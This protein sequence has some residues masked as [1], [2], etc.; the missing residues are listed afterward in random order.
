MAP[1]TVD[2]RWGYQYDT[3]KVFATDFD[4]LGFNCL[5]RENDAFLI[6]PENGYVVQD[7]Y[8]PDNT[9]TIVKEGKTYFRITG[10]GHV[11]FGPLQSIKSPLHIYFEFQTLEGGIADDSM[12][13]PIQDWSIQVFFD[14]KP[15]SITVGR[16]IAESDNALLVEYTTGAKGVRYTGSLDGFN[17]VE[18]VYNGETDG[19]GDYAL[20]IRMSPTEYNIHFHPVTNTD[21]AVSEKLVVTWTVYD[22]SDVSYPEGFT[23]AVGANGHV[24]VRT[25]DGQKPLG[26]MHGDEY[27]VNGVVL[28]LFDNAYILHINALAQPEGDVVD[29]DSNRVSVLVTTDTVASGSANMAAGL[30][31]DEQLTFSFDGLMVHYDPD[32]TLTFFSSAG[33]STGTLVMFSGGWILEL[34]IIASPEVML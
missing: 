4:D 32:G 20:T 17:A 30:L 25:S 28:S 26:F 34:S 7:G 6:S 33:V 16:T 3:V 23:T 14:S 27:S 13:V 19:N 10:E 9:E 29:V 18:G 5:V 31:G 12:L 2:G 24:M 15:Y 22:G 8:S 21:D 11:T 1:D